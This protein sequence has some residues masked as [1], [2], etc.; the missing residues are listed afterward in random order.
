METKLILRKIVFSDKSIGKYLILNNE[1]GV[2]RIKVSQ[3]KWNAI[4]KLG[5]PTDEII[6][7]L[8][9]NDLTAIN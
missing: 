5:I 8:T 9:K 4:K 3:V 6:T 1:I 7:P 2:Y